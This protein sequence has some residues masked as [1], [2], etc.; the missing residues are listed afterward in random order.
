MN[1]LSSNFKGLAGVSQLSW[2][3]LFLGSPSSGAY[4]EQLLE[5]AGIDVRS[6]RRESELFPAIAVENP[7]L[8]VI[9]SPQTSYD[10]LACCRA[11]R[12][13]YDVPI[14]FCSSS[15]NEGDVVQAFEAGA[16]DFLL[17]PVRPAEL[18]A[19]LKAVARRADS[20]VRQTPAPDRDHL[21][22]G[23]IELRL[24]ERLVLKKRQ[25]VDLSPIEFRLLACLMRESGRVMTHA[26]LLAKVWGPEYADS[27]HYLRL[28]IRYLR[29]KIEDDPRN[30]RYILN[31][32]GVG[33]RFQT[34]S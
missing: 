5:G 4:F 20:L 19:R 27:R 30:P 28:Y 23:D 3:M 10:A 15:A 7:N 8:I 25:P 31:E 1:D 11:L 34:I 2:L 33:Y 12:Q 9:E 6:L 17:L 22:C 29:S 13:T 24:R 32:W 21:I 26:K 18:V 16:D 14:V